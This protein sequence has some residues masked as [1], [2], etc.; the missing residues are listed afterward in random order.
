MKIQFALA[1]FLLSLAL[2]NAASG[3][4]VVDVSGFMSPDG[5]NGPSGQAIQQVAGSLD[6]VRFEQRNDQLVA[7][8]NL[9]LNG[10]DFGLVDMVVDLQAN[11]SCPILHLV[12]GPVDLNLLG[13]VIH[14]DTVVLDITAIPG[15]GN[16]LGNL[17]CAIAGLLNGNLPPVLMD[18]LNQIL[19]LIRG[20][21]GGGGGIGGIGI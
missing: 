10:I 2:I 5:R 7:V 14:L 12:L 17:L 3:Q 11:A 1:V 20:A 18:L 6:I 8:A 15:P 13:L 16:L 9:V 21:L 19:D 4:L